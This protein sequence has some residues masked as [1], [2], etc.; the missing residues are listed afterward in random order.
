VCVE[1]AKTFQEALGL[2]DKYKDDLKG[3]CNGNIIRS[4]ILGLVCAMRRYENVDENN[5]EE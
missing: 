2:E 5:T 3:F 4:K 1:K